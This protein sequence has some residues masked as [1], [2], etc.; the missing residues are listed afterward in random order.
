MYKLILIILLTLSIDAKEIYSVDKLILEALKNSPDLDIS[1][2][3]YKASQSRYDKAFSGYLPKLDLHLNAGQTSM[4]DMANNPNNMIDDTLMLGK[5]SLKQ[6]IYDFGKTGGSVDSFKYDSDSYLNA[7]EQKISDKKM[8]VKTT[9][10]QVLQ[11]IALINVN[12]ENV[13][14]NEIQLYRSKKYFEAGIRTK[15]DVSDAKVELIKSQLDLKK[16]L[17]DLKLSYADLDEVVGFEEVDKRYKVY[18]KELV[19]ETIYESLSD[20]DLTL[21][22]SIN[23]AYKN[24]YELKKYLSNI[25]STKASGEIA[26]SE[27]YPQLYFNADYTKQEVDKLKVLMPEQQWNAMLNLDWNIYQG[28]AT[29]AFTQEQQINLSISKSQLQSSKLSIK[30]DITQAYINI[31]KTKDSVELSQSLLEVSKEKF[32]QAQQRYE[33]GL[34]DYIELQQARQGYIDAKSSLVVDYYNYYAAI[35]TLDNAIGK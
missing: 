34:S 14:L 33:H 25:Q 18:S 3:E 16:S 1:A 22:D 32:G 19:L 26:S 31:H 4:S 9:Y 21:I 13:K 20:Y 11:S 28:G 27:Y 5:L 6:I 15:I 29:S 24:R 10:Y 2:S 17:Y 12:K 30:K 23:F 8:D 7:N 35:A